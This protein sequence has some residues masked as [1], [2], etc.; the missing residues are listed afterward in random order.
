MPRECV[1]G[2]ARE[3]EEGRCQRPPR[4]AGGEDVG[5]IRILEWVSLSAADRRAAL[6]RP[7]QEARA[8][9]AAVAA[10]VVSAVRRDGDAALFS[11]TERFDSVELES[12]SGTPWAY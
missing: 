1:L 6:A 5:M 11:L 12:L 4:P 8:D 10:D 9:I 2:N 7:A 3:P